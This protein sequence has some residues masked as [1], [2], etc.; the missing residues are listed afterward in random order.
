VTAEDR[1]YADLSA[2]EIAYEVA[3]HEAVFTVEQ[4]ARLHEELPGAHSKNLF[5]KD[6]DGRYWL[7]TVPAEIRVAL[8]ALPPVIGSRRLSFGNAEDMEQ[9]LGV[10]PGSVTPLAA[11]N[12]SAGKVRVVVD[13][14]L[15]AAARVWVHPLRNTASLALSGQDL[16]IALTSWGQPPL[17]AEVP[18][19]EPA[20]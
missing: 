17:I 9:L 13:H 6:Q 20:G 18:E 19:M 11:M 5:L 7:V 3:E 4:S 12:D 16:I 15:A 8:K 10:T 1:I 14:R 2:H